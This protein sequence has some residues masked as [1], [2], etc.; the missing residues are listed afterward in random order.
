MFSNMCPPG[1]YCDEGT[2]DGSKYN[3]KCP[4]GYYCPAATEA[5]DEFLDS[6]SESQAVTK[7]PKG[8]G[9]DSEDGKRELTE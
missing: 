9:N 2:G 7:C 4:E 8:T 5:Y 1:F 3:K 6:T